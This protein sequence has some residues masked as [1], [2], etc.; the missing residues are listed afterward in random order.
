MEL[1]VEVKQEYKSQF[2]GGNAGGESEVIQVFI[3]VSTLFYSFINPD[4]SHTLGHYYKHY[5]V[6]KGDCRIF[7]SVFTQFYQ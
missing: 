5:D 1:Y 4:Q 6:C 7:I 2:N 3:S